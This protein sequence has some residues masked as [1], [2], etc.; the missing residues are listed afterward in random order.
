MLM[1]ATTTRAAEVAWITEGVQVIY[2]EAWAELADAVE[3]HDPSY[4]RGE[5]PIVA[6]VAAL[7]RHGDVAVRRAITRAWGRWEDWHVSIGAGGYSPSERWDDAT[8]S[9]PFATLVTH[10]WSNHGFLDPPILDRM[11]RIAPVSGHIIH[12][13]RDVSGPAETA[14]LLHQ[15]WPASTLT[16]IEDE[17]HGGPVMVAAWERANEDLLTI[18]ASRLAS[19][20]RSAGPRGERSCEPT[21]R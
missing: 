12:G 8:F 7:L 20:A 18:A 16:I 17:G 10:Y 11:D 9:V 2:P 15:R 5:T 19:A 4:R 6:A 13:R 3:A 21:G 1:A 14:W